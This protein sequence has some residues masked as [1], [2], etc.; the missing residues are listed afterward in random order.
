MASTRDYVPLVTM[1]GDDFLLDNVVYRSGFVGMMMMMMTTMMMMMSRCIYEF[2]CTHICIIA[3]I[4][5]CMCIVWESWTGWVKPFGVTQPAPVGR[6]GLVETFSSGHGLSLGLGLVGWVQVVVLWAGLGRGCLKN[7]GFII[8]NPKYMYKVI[9][10]V[11]GV[12]CSGLAIAN[13]YCLF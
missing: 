10:G 12:L 8:L 1:V 2:M 7:M 9:A 5:V 13:V 11:K 3:R 4:C 6:V